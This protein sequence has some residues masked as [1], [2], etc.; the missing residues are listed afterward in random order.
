[1]LCLH[2]LQRVA[3]FGAIIYPFYLSDLKSQITAALTKPH[4]TKLL[5]LSGLLAATRPLVLSPWPA[6]GQL[7]VVIEP[8]E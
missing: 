8:A 1:V 5:L 7:Q 6:M 2:I 3:G 4:G